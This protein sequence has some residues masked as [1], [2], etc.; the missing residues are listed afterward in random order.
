MCTLSWAPL[1]GGYALAMNRD[2]RR[3]RSRARPPEAIRVRDIPVLMPTDPDGGGSWISVNARGVSLAL[4]NRYEESPTDLSGPFTS[5]GLLVRDLAGSATQDDVRN[6][7]D[8]MALGSYRPFV[9]ACLSIGGA[10]QIFEWDGV[11]LALSGVTQPGLVRASSGSDQ[12]E[13]ERAR[14]ALF[15]AAAEE[16]G[17]LSPAQLERL[18][19]SHLPRKGPLSICMHR[20]EAATVSLSLITAFPNKISIFYVDGPPGETSGGTEHSL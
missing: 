20:D 3:T 6:E 1:H 7:L 16:S 18:H 10:P 19:R 15:R 13:A 11:R 5:R 12:V 2:E 14:S 8:R 17:G 4:L 9:L